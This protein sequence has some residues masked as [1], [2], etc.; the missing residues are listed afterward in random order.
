MT[1]DGYGPRADCRCER[2]CPD[3]QTED[4][5]EPCQRLGLDSE[6]GM[7]SGGSQARSVPMNEAGC[8]VECMM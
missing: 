3:L 4:R 7:G 5:S 8:A 6:D 2:C 1:A